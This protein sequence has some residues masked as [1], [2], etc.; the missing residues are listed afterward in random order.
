MLNANE[1]GQGDGRA[2]MHFRVAYRWQTPFGRFVAEYGVRTLSARLGKNPD[3]GVTP[4]AIYDWISGRHVP[5][6][7]IALEIERLANGR[8]SLVDIYRHRT[9]L[10]R[11]RGRS[12]EN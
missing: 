5:R 10:S 2:Q 3:T 8:I 11:I 6:P 7:Q 9:E 1:R 4:T 12:H